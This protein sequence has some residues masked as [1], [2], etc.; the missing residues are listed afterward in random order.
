MNIARIVR[1]ALL[2]TA[3]L[4]GVSSSF[5]QVPIEIDRAIKSAV[6]GQLSNSG[7]KVAIEYLNPKARVPACPGGVVVGIPQNAKVWGRIN[8]DLRCTSGANWAMNLPIR[9]IVN[10]EYIVASRYIQGNSR[11]S[12]QDL[13]MAQGDLGELPDGFIQRAEQAI[14]RQAIRP[15][16]SGG[17]ITLNNL[18][19]VAVIK[20]GDPVRIQ[21]VGEGFEA[22]GN[23]TALSTAGINEP[24]RVKLP[25]G[26]QVQGRVLSEG[27]VTIKLE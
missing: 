3:L 2:G 15:I 17:L 21:V 22:S 23:G 6:L 26:K 18:K 12:A 16:Q 24:I 1:H 7:Y 19:N 11:I 13:S 27:L 25:D 5:A 8:I 9:V 4:L 20:A 14:G 10:G